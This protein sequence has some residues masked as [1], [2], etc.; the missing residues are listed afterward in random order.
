MA[1]P[2]VGGALG[3]IPDVSGEALDHSFPMAIPDVPGEA[4]FSSWKESFSVI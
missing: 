2:D 4:V 3:H 1:I